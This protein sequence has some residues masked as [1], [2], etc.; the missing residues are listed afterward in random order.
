MV[1]SNYS[2]INDNYKYLFS[3]KPG[4]PETFV[5]YID[6]KYPIGSFANSLNRKMSGP[7]CTESAIQ[8]EQFNNI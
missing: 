8:T 2:I 1:M 3:T 7:I 5:G 6:R 4:K